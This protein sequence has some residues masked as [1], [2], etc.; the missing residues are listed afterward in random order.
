MH[1]KRRFYNNVSAD[2]VKNGWMIKLDDQVLTSPAGSLLIL[3]SSGLANAVVAEWE[4]QEEQINSDKMPIFGLA[5]TVIDRVIPQKSSV[6]S[7]LNRYGGSDLL[8]YRAD[9][10]EL[11]R[12]Q[13]KQWQPWLDWVDVEFGARLEVVTGI[14]PVKQPDAALFYDFLNMLDVWRLGVLHRVVSLGGSLVL[15]LGFLF[16][17]L[18]AEQL[19]NTAF[20]E[21][22]WQNEKWG[23]DFEAKNRRD[24]IYLELGETFRFLQ[25]LPDPQNFHK[26]MFS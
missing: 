13:S 6:I 17:R 21:E 3:P 11:A 22:L 15:G 7:E 1:S 2:V 25:L 9:D 20:L 23:N 18:D 5:V 8:C 26:R 24:Y 14:M 4:A 10:V 19:F 12:Q 16:G